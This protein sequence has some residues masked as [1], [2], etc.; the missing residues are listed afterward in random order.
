MSSRT[1]VKKIVMYI[2]SAL[3][4]LLLVIGIYLLGLYLSGNVHIVLPNQVIRTAQLSRPQLKKVVEKNHIQ[5]ILDLA[6]TATYQQEEAWAKQHHIVYD[7]LPLK[8]KGSCPPNKLQ[9]LTHILMTAKQPLLIHC[10]SGS[11]RTGLASAVM[12]IL[13]NAPIHQVKTQ[14]AYVRYGILSPQSTGRVT[15]I[16]YFQW[17]KHHHWQT[18][19]QHYLAWLHQW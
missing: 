18:S 17:L 6:P 3:V 16:P 12:L 9:T 14:I 1:S 2:I 10:K 11:D 4:C 5:T 13:H 7:Y 8:A 15:L 19:R